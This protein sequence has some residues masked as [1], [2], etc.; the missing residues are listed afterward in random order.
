MDDPIPSSSPA[1]GSVAAVSRRPVGRDE[2]RRANRGWWDEVAEGYQ[3]AHAG[4]LG[5]ARFV[6][7]PEGLD[8]ADARLLGP[9][10]GRAVLEVGCGAAQC[11]RWLVAQGAR[12]TAMD[13]S[14][15]QLGQARALDRAT[16]IPVATL[17]ADA[18]AL[19]FA[20]GAFD[21]ACSAY[22]AVPFVAD[23]GLVMTEVARVLR[24]GGRWVFS[25]THPMRWC[26]AEDPGPDGL[27]VRQSYFDRRPYVE[28][29]PDGVA[30]YAEHHR[31]LGDR[32]RDIVN[33]G[34]TL[35]DVVEPEW[36]ASRT[37]SWDAWSPL[38]GRLMPGTVIFVCDKAW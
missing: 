26:F 3:Q 8:E 19:P 25:V 6:W 21:I 13:L 10:R 22:G 5:A 14:F 23:P 31:T 9:V 4:A 38:R 17:Q 30:T 27:V 36:P 33:A 34:L 37:E 11:G 32:V 16:G 24:P 12:V 29:D 35:R 18:C 15:A 20:D 7:G 2:T 28:E 1:T